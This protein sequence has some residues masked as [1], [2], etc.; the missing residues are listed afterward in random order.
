MMKPAPTLFPSVTTKGSVMATSSQTTG[1][2][3]D[4]RKDRL[5]RAW[6]LTAVA[7]AVFMLPLDYTVVAVALHG[8]Q[9]DLGASY[10]DLQWVVNGY[11]LTF[12]AFLLAGG[13]LADLLGRRLVFLAGMGLFAASSLLCGLAPDALVLNIARAVQGV[14]AASIF[15][16]AVPLL[17]QEFTDRDHRALAFGIFGA[18]VGLGAG[19]GPLIGGAIVSLAGWRWAFLVNVP[20]TLAV[21]ALTVLTVRE[22]RDPNAKSVDWGG[23]ITFT[24]SCFLLI[25]ALVSGN[26]LG[27]WSWLILVS[28]AGSAALMA[29]FAAVERRRAYPMFDLGLFRNIRF[30]GVCIPPLVLSIAFWGVFLFAP[31]YYQVALGYTPL[32][33][34]LA[35]LPFAV[36]LFVMGP[37][38]G[39]LAARIST[40]ALLTL[41][42]LLVGLGS[43]TLLLASRDSG[44]Q[45]FAL[46][47]AVS[48]IG[49]GLINGQMTNAAMSIVPPERSGMASGINGTMRQVGVAL[50][51]AG[52]GAILAAATESAFASSAAALHLAPSD[53]SALAGYV[54]KGDLAGGATTLPVSMQ[55]AFTEAAHTAL[56]QGFR[57][58]SAVAGC[59]GLGGAAATFML[60]HGPAARVTPALPDPSIAH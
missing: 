42:Q 34:G 10:A 5:R 50:G 40:C 30:I 51:F 59:V 37:V 9:H 55:L 8:V 31:M 57:T 32:Q 52:L 53:L 3:L 43:L 36:P 12:A 14:G 38:G 24:M 11:T 23:T 39:W 2:N 15:S 17:V 28:L 44:W 54:I 13:G 46:G 58:I 19:L 60:L 29:V 33:A 27:W 35:V 48:G 56:F 45:S 7:V 25:Y 6:T 21:A 47:A 41:G 16:S 26:E 1:A 4:D 22:S 49:T 18:V 20:V